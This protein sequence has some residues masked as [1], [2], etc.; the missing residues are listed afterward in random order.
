MPLHLVTFSKGTDNYF[1]K[2]VYV[3]YPLQMAHR[4]LVKSANKKGRSKSSALI[5]RATETFSN[6]FRQWLLFFFHREDYAVLFFS[7]AAN[8]LSFLAVRGIAE[9][10]KKTH[11]RVGRGIIR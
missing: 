4:K 1:G 10:L 8:E 2:Y 7:I 6:F 9:S 11:R 3:V 5:E